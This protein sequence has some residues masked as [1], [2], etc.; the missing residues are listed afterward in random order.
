MNFLADEGVDKSIVDALKQ[1]KH[2]VWYIAEISPGI[3]D[4]DVLN[5]ANEHQA[6]LITADKDF[7]DLVFRQKRSN[8]GII[9]IRIEGLSQTEKSTLI[10]NTVSVHAQELYH[11]FTVV[12]P[13]LVRIRK[14]IF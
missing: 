3:S 8:N 10:I 7:G 13:K 4:T 6:I 9:L 11:A 5:I 12:T 2:K 1:E 14:D